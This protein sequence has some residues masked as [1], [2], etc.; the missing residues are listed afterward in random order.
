MTLKYYF[1]LNLT[2]N[3]GL[4]VWLLKSVQNEWKNL[5]DRRSWVHSRED[6]FLS[7]NTYKRTTQ[8]EESYKKKNVEH[9]ESYRSSLHLYD[10]LSWS[11]ISHISRYSCFNINCLN[12][13]LT[14]RIS[15]SY[16]QFLHEAVHDN[17][18][19][20]LIL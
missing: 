12:I 20:K 2:Y 10:R 19:S 9:E 4:A 14:S 13:T 17:N 11:H 8:H 15:W 6:F 18:E 7:S 1:H 16:K 5:Y 3:R